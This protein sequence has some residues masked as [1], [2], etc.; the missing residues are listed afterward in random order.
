[1]K[2]ILTTL[3]GN[4]FPVEVS[5]DLEIINLKALCEQEINIPANKISLTFNG[6]PLSE[7]SKT[8]A[9]YSINENDIIMVQ[10]VRCK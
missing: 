1:M 10:Q 9:N 8:L 4:I 2:I 6:R 7:D 3:E 5:P